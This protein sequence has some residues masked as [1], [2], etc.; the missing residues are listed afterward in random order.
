MYGISFLYYSFFCAL[1]IYIIAIT[2]IVCA[3]YYRIL[4]PCL[5]YICAG[6]VIMLTSIPQGP[7][8]PRVKFVAD[9]PFMFSIIS[10]NNEILFIGRLVKN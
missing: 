5:F 3:L 1:Q 4:P 6:L 10:H 9:H 2:A 7:P 8:R